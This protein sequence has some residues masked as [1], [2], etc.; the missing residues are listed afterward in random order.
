MYQTAASVMIQYFERKIGYTVILIDSLNFIT[1]KN[2]YI[3]TLRMVVYTVNMSTSYAVSNGSLC[4]AKPLAWIFCDGKFTIW[5]VSQRPVQLFVLSPTTVQRLCHTIRLLS[6]I[7][8]VFVP[9]VL[10]FIDTLTFTIW[11]DFRYKNIKW[12]ISSRISAWIVCDGNSS[13]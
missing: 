2:K 10:Y 3:N 6:K 8:T 9:V 11:S 12:N 1:F 13:I 7:V 4:N 5:W